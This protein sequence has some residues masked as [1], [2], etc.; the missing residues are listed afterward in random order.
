MFKRIFNSIFLFNIFFTTS[1]FAHGNDEQVT[2]TDYSWIIY[3]TFGLYALTIVGFIYYYIL[4]KQLKPTKKSKKNKKDLSTLNEKAFKT[5]KWSFLVLILAIATNITYS[6]L[7]KPINLNGIEEY[8][9]NLEI[10]VKTFKSDTVI[11]VEDGTKID[12]DHFPPT[13]GNHYSRDLAYGVVYDEELPDY[14]FLVHNLEHGDIV[15]YYNPKLSTEVQ[16]KVKELVSAKKI[17]SG[18]LVVKNEE[19]KEEIVAT[20]WGKQMKQEKADTEELEQFIYDYIY[21]GPEQITGR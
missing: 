16:D 4:D 5:L 9:H 7:D 12:Y 11:H 18:V 2:P 13:I 20:A 8:N 10:D 17:G 14:E 1:V 6:V 19:I 15:I 3:I 21:R